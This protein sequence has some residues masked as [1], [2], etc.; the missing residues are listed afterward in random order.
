[1]DGRHRHNDGSGATPHWPPRTTDGGAELCARVQSPQSR[2]APSERPIVIHIPRPGA[3]VR[4][5]SFSLASV[6]KE[7]AALCPLGRDRIQKYEEDAVQRLF[8]RAPNGERFEKLKEEYWAASK[9]AAELGLE[10]DATLATLIRYRP[11]STAKLCEAAGVPERHVENLNQSVVK[12]EPDVEGA[13]AKLRPIAKKCAHVEERA[14]AAHALYRA[15]TGKTLGDFS[16]K[17]FKVGGQYMLRKAGSAMVTCT[18]TAHGVPP[19][20]ARLMAR[21][22]INAVLG[23][24]SRTE[25]LLDR[26]ISLTG[27]IHD[28][29]GAQKI[30]TFFEPALAT[31][32]RLPPV[33]VRPPGT[34][35]DIPYPRTEPPATE[36]P[37]VITVRPG[38]LANSVRP[39]NVN[40]PSVAAPALQPSKYP[41]VIFP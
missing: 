31:H 23:P 11:E 6:N 14:T 33:I 28:L 41:Y 19:I 27:H 7:I 4:E 16:A 12:D 1:M 2:L 30:E 26:V 10:R 35:S 15:K 3:T 13:L 17:T 34:V 32:D 8:D 36:P 40:S 25:R 20:S 29:A 39:S 24:P 38:T 21:E 18:L 5:S 22:F 9:A 37:N